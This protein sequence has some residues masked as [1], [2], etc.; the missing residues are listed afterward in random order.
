MTGSALR[1][2]VNCW[3]FNCWDFNRCDFNRCDFNRGHRFASHDWLGTFERFS[4]S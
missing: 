3:D 1:S 2:L 4:H